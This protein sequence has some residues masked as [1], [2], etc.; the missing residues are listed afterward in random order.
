MGTNEMRC[1]ANAVHKFSP[2]N[3]IKADT[4]TGVI[5]KK[6]AFGNNMNRIECE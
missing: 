2:S 6:Y 1:R 4:D 5:R 3:R